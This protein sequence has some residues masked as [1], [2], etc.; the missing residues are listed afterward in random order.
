MTIN[1]KSRE[2]H[3]ILYLLVILGLLI[4]LFLYSPYNI[5]KQNEQNTREHLSAVGVATLAGV[6]AIVISVTLVAVQFSSQEYS[7]RIMEYYLKCLNFWLL[8]GAYICTIFFNILLLNRIE[9]P[10][11][12]LT[13]EM[14]NLSV[15]LTLLC[16]ILLVPHFYL[17]LHQLHPI[18]IIKHKLK[19]VDK[20][21]LKRLQKNWLTGRYPPIT[22]S[23]HVLAVADIIRKSIE[24]N[25]QLI[26][27]EGLNEMYNHFDYLIIKEDD[28]LKRS[29]DN[30][31]ELEE[32]LNK[33]GISKD[34]KKTF[35]SKGFTLS[36]ASLK[37][38]KGKKD[39]W[40]LINE[41]KI[42]I[43][44]KED[45]KLNIYDNIISAYF[46]MHFLDIAKVAIINSDDATITQILKI[47]ED[48]V[49]NR[50][51]K[52]IYG[53]ALYK[54]AEEAVDSKL[55]VEIKIASVKKFVNSLDVSRKLDKLR[56]LGLKV[57]EKPEIERATLKVL[58]GLK[59]DEQG[60][61]WVGLRASRNNQKEATI[62]AIVFL[63]KL[64]TN[65]SE[66]SNMY[67]DSIPGDDEKKLKWFLVNDLGIEWSEN[68]TIN[69]SGWGSY[70]LQLYWWF[71]WAK[72][73]RASD[74]LLSIK[75]NEHLAEIN[76]EE[77]REKATLKI[78]NNAIFEFKVKTENKRLKIYNNYYAEKADR[79]R[80][81]SLDTI[82]EATDHGLGV[83][84]GSE[85]LGTSVG[86]EISKG[87]AK[88][89]DMAKERYC[90]FIVHKD[91]NKE[92][93]LEMKRCFVNTARKYD[94]NVIAHA[95]ESYCKRTRLNYEHGHRELPI[96]TVT[97]SYL[98]EVIKKIKG[99]E[100]VGLEHL[101]WNQ[102][103]L[104]KL[105]FTLQ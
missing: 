99:K 73:M 96:C 13:T 94:A 54:I 55:S 40:V 25:D 88:I 70:V 39:E 50:N 16:L 104:C 97:F 1:L 60:L 69:K 89:N 9:D 103:G 102:N 81:L 46:L 15:I 35:K 66:Y 48:M 29:I 14:L 17:T 36:N 84:L 59:N 37:K 87:K 83:Q 52:E 53:D 63:E 77:G 21:F 85:Y 10:T 38:K 12:P 5:T 98:T 95:S 72:G 8:L 74:S 105:T 71:W 33:G 18:Y 2:N 61:Y 80:C 19:Q 32:N 64:A 79:V 57:S 26:I 30:A 44:K 43:I 86:A 3:I 6:L 34:L 22:E 100:R 27:R 58:E 47:F 51:S 11:E 7:R 42:H 91:D 90:E 92:V 101:E 56:D 65:Y 49:T 78:S 20:R 82:L 75:D 68:A 76:L 28:K 23:D 4:G 41:G 62:D 93:I 67:W 24:S 31:R 45:K